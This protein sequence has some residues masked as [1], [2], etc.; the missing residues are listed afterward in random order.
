MEVRLHAVDDALLLRHQLATS[1]HQPLV[2]PRHVPHLVHD[3]LGQGD[4]GVHPQQLQHPM[5][6]EG[7]GLGRAGK[8]LLETRQLQIVDVQ[9]PIPMLAQCVSSGRA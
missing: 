1:P 2:R 8:Q 6:V 9:Q 5:G 7:V 4:L 3:A